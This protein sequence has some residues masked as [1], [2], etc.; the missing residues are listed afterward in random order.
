MKY[1]EAQMERERK[2][3]LGMSVGS[4]RQPLKRAVKA[5]KKISP[6]D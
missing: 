5:F 4:L 6:A 2:Q 1:S 3:L